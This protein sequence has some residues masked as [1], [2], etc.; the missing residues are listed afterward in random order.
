MKKTK[1]VLILA[2]VTGALLLGGCGS[3]KTKIYEQAGKDLS[4]G[5][6]KYALEEYQS[7]IQN[8]V[9]LAQSYRGA[10]IASL[11]LGKYEDAVNSFTEA[12]NCDKVSKSLRK[13]ILSY[14]AT[15]ELKSGKYEDAMADC[16]TLGEDFSMDAGSYFLTGKV[17]LAMDSYEEAASN[18]KQAYGEDSTYDMAIEIYEAYLDK[19]MEADGKVLVDNRKP[20]GEML[21]PANDIDWDVFT[22]ENIYNWC[23]TAD[24]SEF[25]RAKEAVEMNTKVAT[26]GLENPRGIQTARILRKNVES[27]FVAEDEI[28]HV[29]MWGTA[30]PDARMGGSD[31][32]TMVSTASGNQGLMVVMAPWASAQYRKMSAE[33]GYRAVAF[34]LLMNTFMKYASKEYVYMP[35]TCSC[36]TTAA[37]AAAAGVAFLHGLTPQQINDMLCTAQVQMAG[38]VCDGAKP[39]CATRMYVALFGSLQAMMMAKEGIRATNVEGFVHNDLKVTLENLYRLQH[40]VLHNKVDAILWDIVKEQKVI[41]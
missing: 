4:Q 10:G 15:A 19:D 7:S 24:I 30:G 32:P 5:S 1:T 34:A 12:L 11:R 20:A 35:P 6:Y 39:S 17:A 8:G 41:H 2:A 9:K 27:G 16:Q 13:D 23:K 21:I 3:E 14:R 28:T 18:F 31:Y 29:L 25:G 40:D 26:D 37:P 33:D 22:I 38:V 36:A